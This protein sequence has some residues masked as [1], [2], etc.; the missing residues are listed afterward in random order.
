MKTRISPSLFAAIL[1]V[2]TLLPEFAG[3]QPPI[4]AACELGGLPGGALSLIC[5]PDAGWNGQLVVFAHGY[6]DVHEPPSF[7]D[8]FVAN[9]DGT[10]TF[11]PDLVQSLGYAFATTTYRQNGLAI[12]EGVEDIRELV[13]AFSK[14]GGHSVPLRTYITGVSEGGLVAA[15][16]AEQSPELFTSALAACGPIGSFRLQLDHIGDFR[17]LFD[18]FFP[19]V[20]PGS[21]VNIPQSV[22]ADWQ[23]VYVPTISAALAANPT[24]ALELMHVSKAAYDRANP[25]TIV[26][27]TIDLLRYNILATNDAA[28]K[29]GGSPFGNRLKWYFGSSN[30]LRL[31]LLVRRFTASPAALAALK[32]YETSGDLSVPLVTLH[33]ALDDVVPYWQELLYLGKVD[34]SG[35]GRFVPLPAFRYGHCNFTTNEVLKALAVTVTQP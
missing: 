26:D 4:P 18:Y 23:T 25:A 22:I 9:G 20:I 29:L 12:L 16:L 21:P 19:G 30:D 3:A 33:T 1:A 2:A 34:L 15:L 6:V 5:V 35:R 14:P 31:N 32:A 13:K 17:V 10:F 24:R 27:T 8:L 11:L 7:S 28:Q